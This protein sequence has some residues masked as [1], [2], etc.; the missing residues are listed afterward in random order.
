VVGDGGIVLPI[1]I[2]AWA[3]VPER[4][5]RDGTSLVTAGHKRAEEFTLAM[6]GRDLRAVYEGL[7]R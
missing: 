7:L 1:D 2:D 4:V 6:S 5:R 3:G